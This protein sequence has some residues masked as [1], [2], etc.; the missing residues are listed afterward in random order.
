MSDGPEDIEKELE[1][2][3]LEEAD[4][5]LPEEPEVAPPVPESAL[6]ARVT[7]P[8][9][10]PPA[11]EPEAAPPAPEAEVPPPA[12]EQELSRQAEASQESAEE[13]GPEEDPEQSMHWQPQARADW[14]L[15]G[16]RVSPWQALPAVQEEVAIRG[17]QKDAVVRGA[18]EDEPLVDEADVVFDTSGSR[19]ELLA[20]IRYVGSLSQGSRIN[21][22]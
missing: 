17:G 18:H 20:K 14:L 19:K 2:L 12:T 15:V 3:L 4:T 9:T 22:E 21:S 6:P 5:S 11:T 8:E 10:A 7:R 13:T 1:R 16:T